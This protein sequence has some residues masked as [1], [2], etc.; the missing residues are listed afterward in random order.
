MMTR[1]RN[2]LML[3]I[4][5]LLLA[6]GIL[7]ASTPAAFAASGYG[8]NQVLGVASAVSS[9]AGISVWTTIGGAG[10]RQIWYNGKANCSLYGH[11]QITWCGI[12][13]G[14]GTPLLDTGLNYQ[15]YDTAGHLHQYYLRFELAATGACWVTGSFNAYYGMSCHAPS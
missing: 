8:Y 6:A 5:G 12:A 10:N 2:W 13:S 4:S 1:L 3:P 14:N 9:D 15:A 11:G 7:F